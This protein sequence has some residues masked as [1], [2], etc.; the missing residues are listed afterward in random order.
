MTRTHRYET[1]GPKEVLSV[2]LPSGIG[3]VHIRTGYRD[4]RTGN[5]CVEVEVV[6][7]TPDTPAEDGRYYESRIDLSTDT[8]RLIGYPP[9]D[10]DSE[11]TCGCGGTGIHGVDHSED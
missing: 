5:P 2:E 7:N 4:T 10:P 11:R 1:I 8:V 9:K 6:S 3:V